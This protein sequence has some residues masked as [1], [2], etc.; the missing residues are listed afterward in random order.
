LDEYLK[1]DRSLYQI[2]VFMQKNLLNIGPRA[3]VLS[4]LF[5]GL[6]VSTDEKLDMYMD[7]Q[8]KKIE[9]MISLTTCLIVLVVMLGLPRAL[10]AIYNRENQ[11][12]SIL[13]LVP[14]SIILKNKFLKSYLVKTSGKLGWSVIQA[15]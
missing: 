4:V 1:S 15:V 6:W 8:E 2:P 14:L 10:K 5:R 7:K 12:K 13:K 3:V 11:L 9:I